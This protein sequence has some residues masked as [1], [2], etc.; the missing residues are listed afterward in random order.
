M[1]KVVTARPSFPRVEPDRPIGLEPGTRWQVLCGDEGH[2]R[3]GLYSPELA[4]PEQVLE[5]ERHDCPEL[6][7]LID[8]ELTLVLSDRAGGTR[9][10]R[11]EP[12]RPVLVSAPHSGY[13]PAGPFTGRALVVERDAFET[14]YRPVA[15]WRR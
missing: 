9:E 13:C 1:R 7:F 5:L 15:A 10:V 3:V 8:G 14:E 12:G 2:Y 6:F 4:S 11:L